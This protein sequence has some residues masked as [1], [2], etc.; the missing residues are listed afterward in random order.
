MLTGASL[1]EIWTTFQVFLMVTVMNDSSV[2]P[3]KMIVFA[4]AWSVIHYHVI[5]R[6]D[7]AFRYTC[8]H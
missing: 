3:S 5:D 7:T 2:I 1:V 4:L 8:A 6:S